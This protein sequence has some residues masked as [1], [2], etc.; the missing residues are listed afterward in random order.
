MRTRRI[1]RVAGLGLNDDQVTVGPDPSAW[2]NV[3]LLEATVE[4]ELRHTH[5]WG[6]SRGRRRSR[7]RR[8]GGSWCRLRVRIRRRRFRAAVPKC[9]AVEENVNSQEPVW[10]CAVDIEDEV[11]GI[12]AGLGLHAEALVLET[13]GRSK[14][15]CTGAVEVEGN[16]DFT[17]ESHVGLR[18]G[19]AILE[20]ELIMFVR[21]NV[22]HLL[23]D[24]SL[25]GPR[26]VSIPISLLEQ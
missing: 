4:Q 7:R 25:I 13:S 2:A 26:K 21:F 11:D 14:V 17:A 6:R 3:V 24:P 9:E 20:L 19:N 23:Q 15:D 1:R 16:I 8:G 18:R 12:S 10:R 22:G 5:L